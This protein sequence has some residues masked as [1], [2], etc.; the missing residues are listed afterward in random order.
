[1]YDYAVRRLKHLR[2]KGY[3]RE[4]LRIDR[5]KAKRWAP[6]MKLEAG[7]LAQRELGRLFVNRSPHRSREASFRKPTECAGWRCMVGFAE[8]LFTRHTKLDQGRRMSSK[9]TMIKMQGS[10]ERGSPIDSPNV[11]PAVINLPLS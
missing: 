10:G 11:S 2:C 5:C 6:D 1:M 3:S 9:E 4:T 7:V 8:L